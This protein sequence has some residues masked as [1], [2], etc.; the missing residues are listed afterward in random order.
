MY[1]SLFKHIFSPFN[2]RDIWEVTNRCL[3]TTTEAPDR[4]EKWPLEI[5]R[6]KKTCKIIAIKDDGRA[7]ERAIA[8]QFG[9]KIT[10]IFFFLSLSLSFPLSLTHSF[11]LSLCL[12]GPAVMK[13]RAKD[14]VILKKSFLTMTGVKNTF[15]Q[16][17]KPQRDTF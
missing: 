12:P 16:L 8:L 7:S 4:E 9:R 5:E 13:Y 1:A 11:F 2:E 14:V 17:I 3:A 10:F 15:P 6:R